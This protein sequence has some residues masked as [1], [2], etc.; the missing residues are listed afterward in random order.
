LACGGDSPGSSTGGQGGTTSA[1]GAM[2][3]TG[4][5]PGTGGGAPGDAGPDVD[6]MFPPVDRDKAGGDTTQAERMLLCDWK[7]DLLGGYG[8]VT[9]CSTGSV[10]NDRDQA[11]CVAS[12]FRAGCMA[13]VGDFETC[14]LAMVP[15]QG[16]DSPAAQ[17][18]KYFNC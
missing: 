5:A 12:I 9:Q 17:C 13:T 6:G 2:S 18:R 10:Q 14:I 4:G 7:A 1:T 3:S 11:A 8:H 16:C 15:S